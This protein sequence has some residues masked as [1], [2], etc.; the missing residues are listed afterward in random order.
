MEIFHV[1][2]ICFKL[3]AADCDFSPFPY[4]TNLQQT[5]LK[6]SSQKA[7]Y[8]FKTGSNGFPPLRSGVRG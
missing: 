8:F 7:G 6:T 4:T 1:L 2:T 5:T 3:S